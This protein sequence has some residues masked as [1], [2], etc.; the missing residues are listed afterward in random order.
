M[1]GA[2]RCFL[3]G[4]VLLATAAA[5]WVGPARATD[6]PAFSPVQSESETR[7]VSRDLGLADRLAAWTAKLG[8]P[9][10]VDYAMIDL[11]GD[12]QGEIIIRILGGETCE[13]GS[14]ETLVFNLAQGHWVPVLQTMEPQVTFAKQT[15][16]GYRDI[17]VGAQPWVWAGKAYRPGP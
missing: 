1:T 14:C 13:S 3:A 17:L 8:W 10:R 5:P 11:D 4:L 2:R 9:V 12:G 6:V 16:R 15:H 7:F